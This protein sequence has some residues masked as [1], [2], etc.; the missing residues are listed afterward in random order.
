LV[1]NAEPLTELLRAP[2]LRFVTFEFFSF[3]NPRWHA[4]V[5]VLED[6][7]LITENTFESNCS[8]P[9]GGRTIITNALKKNASVTEINLLAATRASGR[10]FSSLFL[11]LGMNTTLK[12]LHVSIFSEFGDELSAA[13]RNGLAKN[14]TLEELSLYE[15]IPSGN[16]GAVSAH[17]MHLILFAPTPLSNL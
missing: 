10:W 13:I 6:G 1:N 15:M 2:A 14:S 17:A 4:M 8:F 12:S 9:D 11:S 7:S 5:N 3:T 16:D